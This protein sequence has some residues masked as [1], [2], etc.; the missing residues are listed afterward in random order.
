MA[1]KHQKKSA[2]A[3]PSQSGKQKSRSGGGAPKVELSA[4]NQRRIRQLLL[5]SGRSSLPSS[6]T[7][8]Q[9]SMSKAQKAKKLRAIYDQ[10][11]CEGFRPEQI[12]SALSALEDGATFEAALDWLCLNIPGN[13]LPLK[14]SSLEGSVNV[15]SMA[16]ADWVPSCRSVEAE[17]ALLVPVRVRGRESDD[18]DGLLQVSQADWIRHYVQQQEEEEYQDLAD[19]DQHSGLTILDDN[20]RNDANNGDTLVQ[21][22]DPRSRSESIVNELQKA[23]L[24]A[25]E[26]KKKGNKETQELA[27]QLIR[28][29]RH[30]MSSLGS[31]LFSCS[32]FL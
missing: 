25:L 10:L 26:A 7:P 24:Q 22:I 8:G 9:P 19:Y 29:L 15:V 30:E 3:K 17:E 16:Q 14:F 31:S 11:S 4:E 6:A 27:G 5:N 18:D 20:D 2:P 32:D 21:V 1:P 28:K 12:E 13:E 23:R